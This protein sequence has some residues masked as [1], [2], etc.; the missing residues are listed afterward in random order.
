MLKISDGDI[1]HFSLGWNVLGQCCE[2][3]LD[4][5][6]PF[7]CKHVLFVLEL[8]ERFRPQKRHA[9]QIAC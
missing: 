3:S 1:V 8:I 5:R 9:S 4:P 2:A 7:W 6:V